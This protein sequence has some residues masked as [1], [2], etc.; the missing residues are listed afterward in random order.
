[1]DEIDMVLPVLPVRLMDLSAGRS[2]PD[3][4]GGGRVDGGCG[5]GGGNP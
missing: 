5:L 2:R 3:E 4:K 1:M